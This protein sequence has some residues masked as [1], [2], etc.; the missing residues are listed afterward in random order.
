ML[1]QFYNRKVTDKGI[2]ETI[3]QIKEKY[4]WQGVTK[5]VE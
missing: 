5:D 4:N 3:R 2:N 1:E